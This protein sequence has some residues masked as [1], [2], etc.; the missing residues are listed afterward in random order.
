MYSTFY[1]EI[2]PLLGEENKDINRSAMRKG[3]F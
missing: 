2:H 3:F 1:R